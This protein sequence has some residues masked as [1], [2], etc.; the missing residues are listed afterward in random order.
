MLRFSHLL[1]LSLCLL[2]LVAPAEAADVRAKGP[3]LFVNSMHV[4]TLKSSSNGLRPSIR[5]ARLAAALS[6]IPYL[7]GV[8]VAK[9]EEAVWL[10]IGARQILLA[11]PQEAA[12]QRLS[13]MGLAQQ[14]ASSLK[15]ALALPPLQLATSGLLLGNGAAHEVKLIGSEAHNAQV[16]TSDS[17]IA[18][19]TR[20]PQG[21]LVKA[22]SPGRAVILVDGVT[23]E[24]DLDVEVRPYAA[25]FPQSLSATVSGI[26]AAAGTVKGAVEG[27]V[28]TQLTAMPGAKWRFQPFTAP[29][30]GA[31]ESRTF[32]VPVVVEAPGALEKR[33]LVSVVVRNLGLKRAE[34]SELWYS[35]DPETV[36]QIGPLFS[37]PLKK[38][39]SARLL[40]HHMNDA[41]QVLFI[42]VQ[43]VNDTDI[44]AKVLVIPGDSSPDE[45]P[46]LA[47][48]QAAHQ[49][50]GAWLF[51]SGEVVT[52]PPRSTMPVSLR[53]LSPREVTSGLCSVYLTEGPEQLLVRTDAIPPFML[54]ERWTAAVESST[55]WR[56]V[57]TRPLNDYDR[58]PYVTSDHI[59]PQPFRQE[60]VAYEVGGRYGFVRIGQKPIARLNQGRGLEGNFG[61]IYNISAEVQNMTPEPTE[62]E[63]VFEASAGY[64]GGL[65][66]LNGR[67]VRT[68]LLQAKGE[69]RLEKFR[70]E[71]GTKRTITIT[72][73]PLS[74][75]SYPATLTIR[76]V[77]SAAA[78]RAPRS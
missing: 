16:F 11:S 30:L 9:V 60:T 43:A 7:E 71:P 50:F 48:L 67:L 26:P 5:A 47:G 38:G 53:R 6:A 33:G 42:R 18:T 35:N 31:G 69:S 68:P 66:V 78:M 22:V 20:S 13:P 70:M 3:S 39:R 34:D 62:V 14:W 73:L 32:N 15:K 63:I 61:V 45:N 19:V 46:V 41:A 57:G 52:I 65:F 74:G 25:S 37:A 72:T 23:A 1:A 44:P 17:Q 28:R 51:G 24:E 8:N 2:A 75:S 56:E 59:Y 58:S 21:I 29:V 10:K 4:L 77:Q 55:P 36:R 12:L 27:A 76:P 40:Y 54:D 64:S 49:Y